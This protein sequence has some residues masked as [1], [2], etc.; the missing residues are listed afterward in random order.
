MYSGVPH[1]DT[2]V[3][4]SRARLWRSWSVSTALPKS[5]TRTRSRA[6]AGGAGGAP[7]PPL[8]SYWAACARMRPHDPESTSSVTTATTVD[9]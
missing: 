7:P 9:A 8:A 2:R 4:P 3:A 1:T 5:I 6:A